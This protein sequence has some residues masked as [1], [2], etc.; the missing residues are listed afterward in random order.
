MTQP[1]IDGFYNA[2]FPTEINGLMKSFIFLFILAISS[3]VVKADEKSNFDVVCSFAP[4]QSETVRNLLAPI[5]VVDLT[6]KAITTAT[7]LS[8]VLHSS[9]AYIFTGS[10]G[11]VAGTLGTAGIVPFISTITMTYGATVVGIELLCIPKNNP[12]LTTKIAEATKEFISRSKSNIST[13][14]EKVIQTKNYITP[15]VSKVAATLKDS[16]DNVFKYAFR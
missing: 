8:A 7:G 10:S 3:N 2:T 15:I 4:S 14:S 12:E 1:V 11:Y 5:G 9:G 16:S 13:S 6:A